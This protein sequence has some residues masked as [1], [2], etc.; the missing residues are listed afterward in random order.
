MGH[1]AAV[2]R[3][4]TSPATRTTPPSTQPLTTRKTMLNRPSPVAILCPSGSIKDE[5]LMSIYIATLK[6]DGGVYREAL[7]AYQEMKDV[8][9]DDDD[10]KD[11][12][13]EDQKP[14][15]I[16]NRRAP[17]NPLASPRLGKYRKKQVQ[18]KSPKV[19][20]PALKNTPLIGR[21]VMTITS[22][23]VLLFVF[24]QS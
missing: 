11:P 14:Q 8:P 23:A 1:S 16:V 6:E 2:Q 3:S 7:D 19:Q 5:E 15:G 4:V 18:Q 9:M 22:T 24:M 20:D 17:L 12:E 13:D 21:L 10:E